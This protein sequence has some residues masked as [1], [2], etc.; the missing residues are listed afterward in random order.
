MTT[1][2]W[3]DRKENCVNGADESDCGADDEEEEEQEQ[4]NVEEDDK[5][6]EAMCGDDLG[7][8]FN[9]KESKYIICLWF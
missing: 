1:A 2:E 7:I 8:S 3:C 9:Y 5:D 4:D 6:L